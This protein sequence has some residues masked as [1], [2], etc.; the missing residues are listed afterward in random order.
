MCGNL[1]I[2]RH[3]PN[4][5]HLAESSQQTAASLKDL[6]LAVEVPEPRCAWCHTAYVALSSPCIDSP[7]ENPQN[8]QICRKHKTNSPTLKLNVNSRPVLLRLCTVMIVIRVV[9]SLYGLFQ[10][11]SI[12]EKQHWG[13]KKKTM[14]VAGDALSE[15]PWSGTEAGPAAVDQHTT[16]K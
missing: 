4:S 8:N 9:G 1:Y 16:A 14:T 12:Q 10:I 5:P 6:G 3:C 7:M 13:K 2:S 11:D 15:W